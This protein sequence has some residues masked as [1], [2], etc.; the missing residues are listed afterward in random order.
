MY[1]ESMHRKLSATSATGQR[2]SP[3]RW[4]ATE[5]APADT[6]PPNFLKILNFYR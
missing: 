6:L 3:T 4:P 2:L 1:V 5:I